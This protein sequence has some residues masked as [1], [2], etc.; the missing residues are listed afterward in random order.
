MQNK[1]KKPKK[2]HKSK[3]DR[4]EETP[5]VEEGAPTEET[6]SDEGPPEDAE[7]VEVAPDDEGT[8]AAADNAGEP[9]GPTLQRGNRM[10][11]DGRLI[12]GET[13]GA[14]AVFLFER[15]PRPLPS[16][17]KRRRSYLGD[18]VD[19]VLGVGWNEWEADDAAATEPEP[20]DVDEQTKKKKK[21]RSK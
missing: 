8:S 6:D 5:E 11:F 19:G 12:R 3:K 1:K 2:K 4:S 13:A 20:E 7:D 16:M 17:V 9:S 18:T 10:E 21:R 14:G 15:A